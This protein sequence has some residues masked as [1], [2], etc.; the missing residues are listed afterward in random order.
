MAGHPRRGHHRQELQGGEP[1]H[2]AL[3]PHH[4]QELGGQLGL[5][6]PEHRLQR[7]DPQ[8]GLHHQLHHVSAAF[9]SP[10][11]LL[12]KQRR[13]P[14]ALTLHLLLQECERNRI[15]WL[16][17]REDG[18]QELVRPGQS[19]RE[20]SRHR[21]VPDQPP[22]I[23]TLSGVLQT[24]LS[25][26]PRANSQDM[27]TFKTEVHVPPGSNIEFELHYQEMMHRKLGSYQHMLHLQ[28]GRLVPHFQVRTS[29]NVR[30]VLLHHCASSPS[31]H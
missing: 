26:S 5:Q 20:G 8:T 25:L 2:V 16:G 7:P 21:Q 15:C 10:E 17:Q 13:S 12:E 19:Q 9:T 1:H 18:G 23:Q 3:R 22:G 31:R 4:R 29:P 6:S 27:E 30:G 24:D 28:P 11:Q 14:E